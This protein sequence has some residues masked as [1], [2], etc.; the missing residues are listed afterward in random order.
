MC[1]PH[2]IA[3]D[4]YVGGAGFRKHMAHGKQMTGCA[5]TLVLAILITLVDIFFQ[6]WNMN[7][8]TF[9]LIS[10]EKYPELIFCAFV[11]YRRPLHNSWESRKG[12]KKHGSNKHNYL[13]HRF[14]LGWQTWVLHHKNTQANR[15]GLHGI[16]E[17]SELLDWEPTHSQSVPGQCRL[18]S[19][20]GW[21][22]AERAQRKFWVCP[23]LVEEQRV[24][25]TWTQAETDHGIVISQKESSV[26][27]LGV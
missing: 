5:F 2:I 6:T 10:S 22:W 16:R 4:L 3:W 21:S 24:H 7:V 15:L 9:T 17:G 18:S 8:G 13:P 14:F 19:T 12:F 25:L 27:S 1:A 26:V 20:G 23:S 11:I